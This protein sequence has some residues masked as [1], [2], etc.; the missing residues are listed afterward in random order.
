MTT[1][2]QTF[3]WEGSHKSETS[4]IAP[5]KFDLGIDGTIV[6]GSTADIIFDLIGG[7]TFKI[8][9]MTFCSR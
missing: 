5:H 3:E 9:G 8:T 2:K 6:K 1:P 4:V 7:G